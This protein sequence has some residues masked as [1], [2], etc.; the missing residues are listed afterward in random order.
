MRDIVE[1]NR[2]PPGCLCVCVS[3]KSVGEGE[4]GRYLDELGTGA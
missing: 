4:R 2:W 3:Q 1:R